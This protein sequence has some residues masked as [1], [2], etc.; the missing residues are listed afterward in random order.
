MPGFMKW[1]DNFLDDYGVTF[2][3]SPIS[4]TPERKGEAR[5]HQES[6]AEA[7]YKC[8]ELP[9]G[10]TRLTRVGEPHPGTQLPAGILAGIGLPFRDRAGCGVQRQSRTAED[11]PGSAFIDRKY[12]IFRN[13]KPQ[14]D[15]F[16]RR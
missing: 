2:P 8:D 3:L 7:G 1:E 6:S 10:S 15:R 5:I 12:C 16:P 14:A 13:W 11:V 9:D 4:E